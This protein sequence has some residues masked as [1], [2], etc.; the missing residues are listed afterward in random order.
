V[1]RVHGGGELTIG[2]PC[3]STGCLKMNYAPMKLKAGHSKTPPPGVAVKL[4]VPCT[5]ETPNRLTEA[6]RSHH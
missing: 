3:A 1:D 6:G 5:D 2:V 4:E